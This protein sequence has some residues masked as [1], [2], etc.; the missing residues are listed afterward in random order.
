MGDVAAIRTSRPDRAYRSILERNLQPPQ[1]APELDLRGIEAIRLLI[2]KGLLVPAFR[3]DAGYQPIMG[4]AWRCDPIRRGVDQEAPESPSGRCQDPAG[5]GP[6]EGELSGDRQRLIRDPRPG[7]SGTGVSVHLLITRGHVPLVRV[8]VADFIRTPKGGCPA[9]GLRPFFIS[10]RFSVIIGTGWRQWRKLSASS[11]RWFAWGSSR[12][13][14]SAEGRVPG[15]DRPSDRSSQGPRTGHP[16]LGRRG[17]RQ[18]ALGQD[19]GSAWAGG[20]AQE[21]RGGFP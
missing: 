2:R 12:L 5:R 19:C 20:Q 11:K 10:G 6:A 13:T 18:G 14:P 21:A 15:C 8:P 9:R 4:R 16:A 3:P 17:H 7:L 1:R